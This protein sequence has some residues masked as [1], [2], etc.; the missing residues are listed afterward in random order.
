[1]R[2]SLAALMTVACLGCASGSQRADDEYRAQGSKLRDGSG[3]T[4]SIDEAHFNFHTREGRYAPPPLLKRMVAMGRF[5][6][7]AGKGF[8][9][10]S[11]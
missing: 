3:I 2:R 1:M 11:A 4:V 6:R 10:Y 8:Y 7:K 9:D 5:G